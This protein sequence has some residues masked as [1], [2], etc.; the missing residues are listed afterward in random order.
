MLL[1]YGLLS[2]RFIAFF[3]PKETQI[4]PILHFLM[5]G[6]ATY[7]VPVCLPTETVG[8]VLVVTERGRARG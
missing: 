6:E 7:H 5:K 4:T 1:D 2:L 3:S 8:L